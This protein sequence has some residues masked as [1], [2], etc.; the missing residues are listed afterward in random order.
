MRT[1]LVLLL[2]AL[3]LLSGCSVGMSY[4]PSASP[5]TSWDQRDCDLRGGYWN[6]NAGVCESPLFGW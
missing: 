5:D 6:R 3:L 1:R 4:D 2:S